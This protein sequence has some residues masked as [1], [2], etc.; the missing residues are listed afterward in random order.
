MFITHDLNEALKLGERIAIMR[1]GE[2]I[3][4]GTPEEI[5]TLPADAYVS[6]FVRDVSIA[7]V[8]GASSIMQDPEAIVYEWQGPR[9]ALHVMRSND[10]DEAFVLGPGRQL[11]GYL[12]LKA[13]AEALRRGVAT[14]R[15]AE[16]PECHE[17]APDTFVED[18]VSL[19][20]EY[21]R[22]IAVVDDRRRL[23]GEI[24]PAAILSTFTASVGVAE[25]E[26][27]SAGDP[28]QET[29]EEGELA[30]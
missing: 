2:I 10:V 11:R 7:K 3:Q 13:A 24:H 18:L 20:T 1:D 22:P 27:A 6:E 19:V 30:T 23:L 26:S 16:I 21:D 4:T 25:E 29:A 28:A 9:V 15:D 14:L 8:V 12:T 17:V 5:V